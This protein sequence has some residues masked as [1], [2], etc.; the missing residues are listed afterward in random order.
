M[1]LCACMYMYNVIVSACSIKALAGL[2]NLVLHS[3][4]LARHTVC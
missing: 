1:Y 3:N 4:D 2:L